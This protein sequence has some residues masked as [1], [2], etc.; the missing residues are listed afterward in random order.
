[1]RSPMDE[2]MSPRLHGLGARAFSGVAVPAW[3][4]FGW[5]DLTVDRTFWVG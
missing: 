4:Q 3:R 2:D 5:Q 1:M